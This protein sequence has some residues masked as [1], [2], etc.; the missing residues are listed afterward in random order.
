M[1]H[2]PHDRGISL[3]IKYTNIRSDAPSTFIFETVK[4]KS[5]HIRKILSTPSIVLLAFVSRENFAKARMNLAEA[6]HLSVLRFPPTRTSLRRFIISHC[7][8]IFVTFHCY[9]HRFL[10]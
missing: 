3:P 2:L 9:S 4:A 5:S 7:A 8:I 10:L 6:F 1:H